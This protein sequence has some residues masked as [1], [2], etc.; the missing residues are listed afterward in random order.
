MKTFDRV[1]PTT[2]AGNGSAPEATSTRR[3]P[4]PLVL[5]VAVAAVAFVVFLFLTPE[6]QRSTPVLAVT[7]PIPQ[8]TTI[9]AT[10]LKVVSFP[11]P[12]TL[13]VVRAN[14]RASVVGQVAKIDLPAGA[15]LSPDAVGRPSAASAEVGVALKPGQYP[16][17]I[18]AGDRV[19]VLAVGNPGVT[20]SSATSGA[21]GAS[22]LAAEAT[23]ASVTTPPSDP[24]T[25][26][27]ALVVAPAEAVSVAQSGAAGQV[28]L[29]VER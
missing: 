26:M 27:V 11:V 6:A 14:D 7:H 21:A 23:V 5:G 3:R 29:V 24:G 8:G 17:G 10:D 18:A 2:I 28:V 16:P 19:E 1:K 13:A 9:K 25:L 12:K 22:V 15:L 20:P 4:S